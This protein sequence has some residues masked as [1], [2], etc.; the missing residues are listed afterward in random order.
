MTIKD[1]TIGA[2]VSR[3]RASGQIVR[4]LE[5][6]ACGGGQLKKKMAYWLCKVAEG[7]MNTQ[8]EDMFEFWIKTISRWLSWWHPIHP[9][10]ETYPS[11]TGIGQAQTPDEKDE[12]DPW[13]SRPPF[14]VQFISEWNGRRTVCFCLEEDWDARA[15]LVGRRLGK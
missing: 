9:R 7:N 5:L 15:Q 10:E 12:V 8:M 2:L 6:E 14:L 3:G 13:F 4:W 1:A 11:P